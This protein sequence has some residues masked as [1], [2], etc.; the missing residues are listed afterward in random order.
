MSGTSA[1]NGPS[2]LR[3]CDER[4]LETSRFNLSERMFFFPTGKDRRYWRPTSC[5]NFRGGAQ[6]PDPACVGFFCLSAWAS[7][8][9]GSSDSS[10]GA[11]IRSS[12]ARTW[13]DHGLRAGLRVRLPRVVLTEKGYSYDSLPDAPL[14]ELDGPVSLREEIGEATS[15][16]KRRHRRPQSDSSSSS[17]EVR[18][19]SPPPA[20][21]IG[22]P[23]D[24]LEVPKAS[25]PPAEVI[26]V[27]KASPPAAVIGEPEDE[28][29]VP[30]ASP[31]SAEVI[32]APEDELQAATAEAP[33]EAPAMTRRRRGEP[34]VSASSSDESQAKRRARAPLTDTGSSSSSADTAPKARFAVPEPV[35]VPADHEASQEPPMTAAQS[36]PMTAA[37]TDF[38]ILSDA[39]QVRH[40]PTPPT[41]HIQGPQETPEAAPARFNKALITDT[42]SEEEAALSAPQ[43]PQAET[44]GERTGG[45]PRAADFFACETAEGAFIKKCSGVNYVKQLEAARISLRAFIC[46]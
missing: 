11:S 13:W 27:P 28:L 23:E 34:P 19:A 41:I 1:L 32:G 45:S 12:V 15:A 37:S 4:F 8:D 16:P 43:E 30:K 29:E 33:E 9:S 36:V 6:P 22:A 17:S 44:P 38:S 2:V 26:G 7:I 18:K 3:A 21:V 10:A 35:E 14:P 40:T 20:E 42:S 5:E 31:P 24:E 25:P 39:S 46:I